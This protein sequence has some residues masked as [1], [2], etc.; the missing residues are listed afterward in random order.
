MDAEGFFPRT[1]QEAQNS[2]DPE[3]ARIEMTTQIERA[4]QYGIDVSHIDT[5]MGTVV[6]PKFMQAYMELGLRYRIPG[7][8]LRYDAA[9]WEGRGLDSEA[10]ATA[11]RILVDLEASGLPLVDDLLGLDLGRPE[12]KFEQACQGFASL[13]PGLTH[14]IIHPAVDTPELREIAPDWRARVADYETFIREDL[15]AYI[16]KI[17]VKVIGYRTLRDMM[18]TG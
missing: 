13:K 17:G 4:Y 16:Q 15:R 7:M 12:D 1:S 9:R 11:A 5:H 6:H 3:A 18:R 14:F 8:Y 10:A 2:A